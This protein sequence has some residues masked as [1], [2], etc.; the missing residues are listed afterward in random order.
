MNVGY[1]VGPLVNGR[2]SPNDP[3]PISLFFCPKSSTANLS[4][5]LPKTITV[6]RSSLLQQ[7]LTGRAATM[8]AETPEA[9]TSSDA[10]A[11]AA[12]SAAAAAAAAVEGRVSRE[13]VEKAVTALLKWKE[14]QSEHQAP[15]LLPQDEFVYLNIT[16]KR[17]PS[18]ARTNPFRV[19]LPHT[20]YD[21]SSERCVII[22]D[23]PGSNL[24]SEKAKKIIKSQGVTV[25][26]VLKLSKL[27]TDYKAFEAK[28]KLMGS[29][30]FFM[31]DNRIVHFLPKLLGKHFFKKKRL[32]LPVDLTKKDWKA[33]IERACASGLFFRSTGTSSV[34]KVGRLSMESGEIV[35]NV[36]E[37]INGLVDYVPKRWDGLRSFQ[38]RLVGSVALPL[39]QALPDLKLKIIG[40]DEAETEVDAKQLTDGTQRAG[41][42]KR[43]DRLHAVRYMDAETGGVELESDDEE[44]ENEKQKMDVKMGNAEE[45]I[46]EDVEENESGKS[47]GPDSVPAKL[48]G[49]K[50]LKGKSKKLKKGDDLDVKNHPESNKDSEED[51]SE[52]SKGGGDLVLAK[53]KGKK[54]KGKSPEI[55]ALNG[56]GKS[57]K[58]KRGDDLD[59]KK[60]K[61]TKLSSKSESAAKKGKRKDLAAMKSKEEV[62]KPKRKRN[63]SE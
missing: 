34:M 5:L 22:D 59:D 33:Q 36:M 28:R 17:I 13:T 43:K 51:E 42:K 26:K 60:Q 24:T 54:G 6:F 23:R 45:D 27:R 20:L 19:P 63:K 35:D 41:K 9:M 49:K 1:R 55:Q 3:N 29:Y 12:A 25:S 8:A 18:K 56:K 44:V 38:L 14:S 11:A 37:A 48:K 61:K 50:G 40:A 30:D 46:D 52:K 31:V 53:L 10:A 7:T 47:K 62:I 21:Q 16:L 39:Y 58:L 57:K 15:Q 2:L 4:S 32:P